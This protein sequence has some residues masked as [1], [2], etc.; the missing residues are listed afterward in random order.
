LAQETRWLCAAN[1][2]GGTDMMVP[3]GTHTHSSQCH[4]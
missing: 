4:C 1:V 2:R 3:A